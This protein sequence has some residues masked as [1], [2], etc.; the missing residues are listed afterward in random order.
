MGKIN[1][2]VVPSDNHGGVGFYRSIQPH[3]Y[4]QEKYK[5]DFD[6]EIDM[7]PDWSNFDYLKQFDI[8]HFHKGMFKNHQE[9]TTAL[10]FCKDNG[11]VTVMDVDD[12]WELSIHHPNYQASKMKKTPEIITSNLKL[13]SYV[14]TTTPIFAERIKKYNPNVIIL[15]NA[16]D[17][18]DP[19][20][21]IVKEPSKLVRVGL[22]MGSTHEHDMA[23]MDNIV[24]RLDINTLNKTQ[25]VLCGFDLRGQVREYD[26]TTHQERTRPMKPKETVWYRYEKMLT[27]NYAIV[28]PQ[29]RSYLEMFLPNVSFPNVENEH[30]RRCWTLPI[31]KYFQHYKNV[32]ILLAPLEANDFN[33]C[34]SQLK[35]IESAF[36]NTAIIASNFGPYTIDLKPM[37]QFGGQIDSNGNAIL[38]DEAKNHKDW[39]KYIA[40]LVN[41]PELVQTLSSNLAR[42]LRPKYSLSKVTAD[43]VNFYKEI[44]KEKK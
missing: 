1:I 31:D 6:V 35:A 8:I 29:Y 20:F 28:S 10:K 44:T 18:E 22:I 21:K 7:S 13:A 15:P 36:S 9:F 4:I 42:D 34:K 23:I 38:I 2:L 12:N 3:V 41:N 24:S 26:M 16:I 40:K 19:S 17:E 27:N 25:F 39:A 30:Y 11:I 37:N 33:K 32:D 14:T 43:R 5:D